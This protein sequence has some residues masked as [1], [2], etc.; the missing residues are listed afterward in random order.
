M[1]RKSSTEYSVDFLGKQKVQVAGVG[2]TLEF[3]VFRSGPDLKYSRAGAFWFFSVHN[4]GF[5]GGANT[6]SQEKHPCLS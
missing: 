5:C 3:A 6:F 1:E 2:T 4:H